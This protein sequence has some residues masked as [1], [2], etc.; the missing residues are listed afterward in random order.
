[1]IPLPRDLEDLD[2]AEAFLDHFGIAHDEPV[3]R[4][5]RLHILQRFHDY[6]AAAEPPAD[7]EALT[8][9]IRDCLARAYDDFVRSDPLTERVFK[10]L[11]EAP[12]Q[13]AAKQAAGR[14][15]VPLDA[16]RGRPDGEG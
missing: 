7:P 12:A 13:A 8:A 11:K 1:M 9:A 15:F 10:V 16:V 14:A 3:V 5:A 4:R 2:T 6:L